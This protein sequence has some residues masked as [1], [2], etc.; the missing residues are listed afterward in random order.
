MDPAPAAEVGRGAG[1]GVLL[2]LQ[3]AQRHHE[4]EQ[5]FLVAALNIF[6]CSTPPELDWKTRQPVAGQV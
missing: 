6:S 1:E 4:P 3:V 5:I 2:Q